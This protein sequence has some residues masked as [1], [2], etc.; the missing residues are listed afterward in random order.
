M[1]DRARVAG[2]KLRQEETRRGEKREKKMRELYV[3]KRVGCSE[4]AQRA[5]TATSERENR[6]DRGTEE[7]TERVRKKKSDRGEAECRYTADQSFAPV[8]Q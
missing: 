5:E 6:R 2:E 7:E 1:S 4:R 3:G 8:G